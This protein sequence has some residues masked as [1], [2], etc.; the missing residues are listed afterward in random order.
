MLFSYVTQ[1]KLTNLSIW[2]VFIKAYLLL[3]FSK[4]SPLIVFTEDIR[5]TIWEFFYSF[6]Q[7]LSN[8]FTKKRLFGQ[9]LTVTELE[10]LV[11]TV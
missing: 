7:S 4:C 1:N 9:T 10:L 3:E 2:F 5:L 8:C 11:R 6:V